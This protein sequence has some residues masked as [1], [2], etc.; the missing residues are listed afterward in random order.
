MTLVPAC[1]ESDKNVIWNWRGR[2]V[3][4]KYWVNHLLFHIDT[5]LLQALISAGTL[6]AS[7]NLR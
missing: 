2:V 1:T 6:I 3:E 5:P 7:F 4:Q